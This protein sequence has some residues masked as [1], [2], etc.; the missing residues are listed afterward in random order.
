MRRGGGAQIAL[1]HLPHAPAAQC[2][3]NPARRVAQAGGRMNEER[4]V[5]N[6]PFHDGE[7]YSERGVV[8]PAFG[9]PMPL[10]SPAFTPAPNSGRMRARAR[11]ANTRKPKPFASYQ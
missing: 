5:S 1:P 2:A 7:N 4:A 9:C 10:R 3:E 11:L 6:G 8:S